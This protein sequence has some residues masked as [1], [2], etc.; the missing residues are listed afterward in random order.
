MKGCWKNRGVAD[1][2][3][4]E[5]RMGVGNSES[6]YLKNGFEFGVILHHVT[7]QGSGRSGLALNTFPQLLALQHRVASI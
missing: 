3:V 5:S 7:S 2:I 4:L 1:A 6:I